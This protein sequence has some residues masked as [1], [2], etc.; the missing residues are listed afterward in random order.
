MLKLYFKEEYLRWFNL[1]SG[2]IWK[3]FII[4]MFFAI[5][6]QIPLLG[7]ILQVI[8]LDLINFKSNF[9]ELLVRSLIFSFIIGFGPALY[10]YYS[11]IRLETKYQK[12][13]NDLRKIKTMGEVLKK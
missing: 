2:R 7:R 9:F 13:A 4:G 1:I 5:I 6:I 12:G 10:E 3:I 8:T 11:K